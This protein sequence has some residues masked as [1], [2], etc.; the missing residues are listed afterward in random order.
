MRPDPFPPH[1]SSR[2]ARFNKRKEN[3]KQKEINYQ[4]LKKK[5]ESTSLLNAFLSVFF[6]FFF[7][8][9]G[10]FALVPVQIDF[11]TP[12]PNIQS[13]M[14]HL[15]VSKLA[16]RDRAGFAN[17]RLPGFGHPRA[18]SGKR[19]GGGRFNHLWDTKHKCKGSKE[20]A[21]SGQTME[22]CRLTP[23]GLFFS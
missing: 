21:G 1:K 13:Q 18:C 9:C 4:C 12:P 19:D 14:S 20:I 22:G 2:K 16:K 8:F 11:P 3:K 5:V 7:L 10:G 17:V 15:H 6:S 23:E